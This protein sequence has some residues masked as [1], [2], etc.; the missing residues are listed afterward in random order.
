MTD[1]TP[2]RIYVLPDL[3]ARMTYA[4]R[5]FHAWWEGFA[6]DAHFERADIV[7]NHAKIADILVDESAT[8]SVISELVWG[9]GHCE[10][11]GPS[12]SMA[13][14]RTL[15]PAAKDKKTL[16]LGANAAIIRHDLRAVFSGPID[17]A[18]LGVYNLSSAYAEYY[19]R[20]LCVF[21]FY[22]DEDVAAASAAL[23]GVMAS[24]G[25]V[26]LVDFT[27]AHERTSIP[28]AFVKPWGGA[29]SY[30]GL[31]GDYLRAA[32]FIIDQTVDETERFMPLIAHGWAGWRHAWQLLRGVSNDHHRAALTAALETYAS[33]WA[34]RYEALRT[35]QLRVTR[36][37]LRKSE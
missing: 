1:A 12:W 9:A 4:G 21:P 7:L 32:D 6:F 20:G 13:L 3:R 8:A 15:P 17:I 2:D 36:F 33:M 35:G 26:S 16:I 31:F 34:E 10:P 18:E 11:G 37:D 24:R 28:A 19:D 5:R 14:A 29:P 23:A 27:I 30:T 22:R 25:R